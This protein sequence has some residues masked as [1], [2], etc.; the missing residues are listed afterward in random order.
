[1]HDYADFCRIRDASHQYY[2]KAFFSLAELNN[3]MKVI[4][5]I[6]NIM[7]DYFEPRLPRHDHDARHATGLVIN[8][9]SPI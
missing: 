9:I 6:S 3:I 4:M 2:F 5:L 7:R 1:M 8:N